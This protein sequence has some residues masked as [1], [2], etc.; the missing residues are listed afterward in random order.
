M[1]IPRPWQRKSSGVWYLQIGKKQYALG[2][3]KKKAEA[4]A[5]R[6]LR[7]TSRSDDTVPAGGCTVG[8]I[9]IAYG[10]WLAKNRAPTTAAIRK[11]LIGEFIAFRSSKPLGDF[12]ARKLTPAHVQAFID[13]RPRTKSP[14]TQNSYIADIIG[15]MNWAVRFGMIESNPI[16]AMPK[17]T[18]RIREVFIPADKFAD[19]IE[20]PKSDEFRD[21]LR[22][23]LET[24][25]RAQE[26]VRLHS[27]HYRDGRFTLAIEDSK[28]KQRSRVIYC[29]PAAREIVE[30]LIR[31]NPTGPVFRNT[32]GQPWDSSSI[33]NQMQTLKRRLGMPKLCATVL[34]HSFAHYRLT[35]GQD[36]V[37][38]AKLMG[39]VDTKMIAKRYGHL[40]GSQFLA[41]K[42]D[43][44]VMPLG[45]TKRSVRAAEPAPCGT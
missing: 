38:V 4:H 2:R 19:L 17:P 1:R 12:D 35:Q 25:A 18:P 29:P 15:M 3:D 39:H 28:G 22:V 37:V 42:A 21:F 30:R 34:R 11:Y 10:D 43:E 41:D 32:R 16:A 27:E 9:A 14:S 36:P 5:N 45:D 26:M 31:D 24:G 20:A 23:M 44:L 40:E 33:N 6:L 7:E 13:S 8:E